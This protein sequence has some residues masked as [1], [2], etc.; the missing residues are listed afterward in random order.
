MLTR[1]FLTLLQARPQFLGV[2]AQAGLNR[3]REDNTT[4]TSMLAGALGGMGKD[5]ITN[6]KIYSV[7]GGFCAW[8][9]FVSIVILVTVTNVP[10]PVCL[11]FPMFVEFVR[12]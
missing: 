4:K 6:M 12:P 7:Y 1:H 3:E 8:T 11:W 2:L 5:V 10:S 9:V